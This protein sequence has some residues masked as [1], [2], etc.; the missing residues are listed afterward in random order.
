[1]TYTQTYTGALIVQTCCNC[2][3]VFGVDSE[4]DKRRRN[5]HKSFYCPNGHSQFYS[6][7]SDAERL[8]DELQEK[9][10]QLDY[11]DSR[12]N[13]LHDKLTQKNHQ[14]RAE[15]GAKT[16]IKNRVKHGVCPC[17]NRTFKQLATHMKDQHPEYVQS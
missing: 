2:G 6:R 15:K 7:K 13:S 4:T 5:D 11:K 12:I 14:L 10:R 9:Q 17:C 3:I 8:K 16:R 1:M